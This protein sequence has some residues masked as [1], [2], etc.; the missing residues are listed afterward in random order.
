M[1][2]V[3][4][5][6][7]LTLLPGN[8][9]CSW[10]DF[11]PEW[12]T[13]HNY[14][15]VREDDRRILQQVRRFFTDAFAGSR[16]RLLGRGIDAGS[17]PN[18]YPSLAM[19]PYCD[20]I[21]LLEYSRA[22]LRWLHR[23]VAGY[24]PSWDAFW[25]ELARSRK[26]DHSQ[27]DD[28]RSRLAE[29]ARVQRGD[30]FTLQPRRPWDLGTMFFVA[31]SITAKRGEFQRALGRFVRAL[32]P[33]APFAAAFMKNSTGYSVGAHRFPAVEVNEKDIQL[34]LHRF[35]CELNNVE[36]IRSTTPLREGYDGMILATGWAGKHKS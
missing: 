10:D 36:P 35:G 4:T 34:Y 30:L 14:Q 17:G 23:E 18:L 28:P 26:S 22:N 29:V 12:Y 25:D 19:L 6:R 9:E 7:E 24:S 20:E 5:K 16:D 2:T 3:R 1:P 32:K 15:E 13:S 33:G 27:V 31:E 21:T 8:A 11:D